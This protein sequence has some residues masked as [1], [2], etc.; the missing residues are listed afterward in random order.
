VELLLVYSN[1]ANSW[2]YEAV[3][4][5]AACPL[6]LGDK[7]S[8][9]SRLPGKA[10]RLTRLQ[11]DHLVER[12]L[13]GDIIRVIAADLKVNRTTVAHH[14]RARGVLTRRR[15]LTPEQVSRAA[16]AYEEGTSLAHIGE[17][18]GVDSS[19][20]WRALIKAG[21]RIRDTHGRER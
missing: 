13:A 18:L 17:Q 9:T 12:Y 4:R 15:P 16:A 21:V 5:L 1:P 20:V 14:L 6:A 8:A 3:L 2:P 11:I 19:T 10:P 7:G